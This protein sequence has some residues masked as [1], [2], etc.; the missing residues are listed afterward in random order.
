MRLRKETLRRNIL[1]ISVG[2]ILLAAVVT[3]FAYIYAHTRVANDVAEVITYSTD[4]PSVAKPNSDHE[5]KGSATDPKKI[6]IPSLGI[7]DY[8]QNVGRDQNNEVAVPNNVHFAGWFVDS[9]RPGDMGLSIIDGHVD[10]RPNHEDAIFQHLDT[11]KQNAEVTVVFGDD[12][13]RT[14]KVVQVQDVPVEEAASVVFSS[15]PDGKR[16]L[17]LVTCSGKYDAA[18]KRLDRRVIVTAERVM[19]S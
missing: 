13:K 2:V 7:D 17:N 15:R 19:G 11:I 5:W 4:T 1:P 16:Q 14:F 9:V 6:I 3:A 8:V 18:T 12:S 10:L